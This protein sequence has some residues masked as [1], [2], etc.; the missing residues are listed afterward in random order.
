MMDAR[1]K[2]GHDSGE[3]GSLLHQPQIPERRFVVLGAIG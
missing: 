3:G 2:P 1:V